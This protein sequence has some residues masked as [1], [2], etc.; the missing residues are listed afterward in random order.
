VYTKTNTTRHLPSEL[1]KDKIVAPHQPLTT[2]KNQSRLR[3]ITRFW[4]PTLAIYVTSEC[5][6]EQAQKISSHA[7]SSSRKVTIRD[8]KR[9]DLL[10]NKNINTSI[11]ARVRKKRLKHQLETGHCN[12][13][14]ALYF[15]SLHTVYL[16]LSP[17]PGQSCEDIVLIIVKR[18]VN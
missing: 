4:A 2:P 12:Y 17:L 15:C 1:K 6:G 11:S 7:Q 3:I 18:R 10:F 5:L 8:H 9:I 13:I 16:C 14:K